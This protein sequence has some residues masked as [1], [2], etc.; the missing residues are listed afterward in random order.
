MSWCLA[1]GSEGCGG[2][3]LNPGEYAALIPMPQL[4]YFL[5]E[6]SRRGKHLA[7]GFWIPNITTEEEDF[8]QKY[9]L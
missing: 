3:L 4:E 6:W 5:E 9:G 7:S 2:L 8:W 1:R